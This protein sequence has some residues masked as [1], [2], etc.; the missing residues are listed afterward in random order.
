MAIIFAFINLCFFFFL[1]VFMYSIPLSFIYSH[2]FSLLC[3]SVYGILYFIDLSLIYNVLL[4]SAK[5]Q[6]DAIIHTYSF[7]ILFHYGLLQDIEYTSLRYT[8]GACSYPSCIYWFASENLKLPIHSS[9]TLLPLGNHSSLC[10]SSVSPDQAT[11]SFSCIISPCHWITKELQASCPSNTSYSRS[12]WLFF[13]MS[14]LMANISSKNTICDVSLTAWS[15]HK[16]YPYLDK[17][18]IERCLHCSDSF[19]ILYW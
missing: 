6:N 8:V 9:S 3:C 17:M 12:T 15:R 4:I 2:H 10:L 11:A 18:R 16:M 1:F 5:Q 14:K 13:F 7:N 19:S